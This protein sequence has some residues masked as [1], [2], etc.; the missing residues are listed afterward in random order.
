MNEFDEHDTEIECNSLVSALSAGN[1]EA[2][3]LPIKSAT[4]IHLL[5]DD[6][7]VSANQDRVTEASLVSLMEKAPMLLPLWTGHHLE[8]TF[9]N[10]PSR[11]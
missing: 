1:P 9:L 8:Q 6:L 4:L 7:L 10:E 3:D 2:S 11:K 5:A